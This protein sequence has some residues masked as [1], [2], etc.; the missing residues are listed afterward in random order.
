MAQRPGGYLP[1][2]A[3]GV[4]VAAMWSFNEYKPNK[5]KLLHTRGGD[6]G[7]TRRLSWQDIFRHINAWQVTF[8]N[9]AWK[10]L[11]ADDGQKKSPIAGAPNST[12]A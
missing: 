6:G 5:K 11:S 12:L 8:N 9:G 2:E 7:V 1:C 4:G 10:R 3:P